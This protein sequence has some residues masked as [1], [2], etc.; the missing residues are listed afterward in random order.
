[1]YEISTW[2]RVFWWELTEI[3]KKHVRE[4][5]VNRANS[6]ARAF[7]SCRVIIHTV[8]SSPGLWVVNTAPSSA[9]PDAE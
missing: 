5:G 4:S 8:G 9:K 1:V 6:M 7:G 2:E 3:F